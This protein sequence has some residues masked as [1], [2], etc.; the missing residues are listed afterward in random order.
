[1]SKL[2]GY[3]KKED[4]KKILL[5]CDD[6]RVHSGIA[7][8]AREIVVKSAHHFNWFQIG[9]ALTHPDQGKIFD[10]SEDI[11]KTVDIDDADVKI[12]P[13][14][15]Y[16]DPTL[17]RNIIKNEK[18]DAIFIFTDPRYW[19][20]LF[21][22]ERELRN[23]MPIVYLNIWDDL[24]AP[25][26]NRDFYRSV[27]ALMAISKQTKFINEFVL[28]KE[29]IG[30]VIEYVPHGIDSNTFKPV[31][32]NEFIDEFRSNTLNGKDIDFILFF[33]SRNIHRKRPHDLILAYRIFC[34]KIGVEAS[35]K[36]A[37][38]MHT[39]VSDKHGTDLK[40]VKEAL[41]DKDTMNVFFS[42]NKLT[43][44]QLNGLYNIADATVL[45]SS[46]EGWGLS[47]TESM[48][49]GTMIIAN[50][51]GGMQDQMRF[52][53]EDG[54]WIDFDANVP[55]NHRGT[56]KKHGE[57]AQPVFPSNISV[58]GSPLTPYIFDDRL[59]PEDLAEAMYEVWKLP[60]EERV[61][62][63]LAGRDWAMSDEAKMSATAM[64]KTVTDVVDK[65]IDTFVPRSGFELIKVEDKESTFVE[66]KLY[67]Y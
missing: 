36:S 47:L 6:I 32:Q 44:H 43:A 57:W 35:K 15:G 66:H 26:Y 31:P 59:T 24:P 30:K 34:D 42:Q 20:W 65:T 19:V 52:E 62:R 25:M 41:V 38:I 2:E 3:I 63:G 46:N 13:N 17:I 4:R 28:G 64:V 60:K 58:A 50:V 53:D 67:G 7:T 51:T 12:L 8:M 55:S 22:M 27:D 9:A 16:G 14:S 49:A 61:K 1:M 23:T 54:N 45:P 48:M 29:A 56:Y 21:E 5:L 10:L 18:P 11:N 37:L 33:N 40:A 39:Q